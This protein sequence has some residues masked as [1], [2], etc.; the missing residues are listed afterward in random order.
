M[1]SALMVL[2]P[3]AAHRGFVG[4]AALQDVWLWRADATFTFLRSAAAVTSKQA[5]VGQSKN[6]ALGN[7]FLVPA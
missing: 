3:G 6:C 7:E 1:D 4:G 5:T 2:R